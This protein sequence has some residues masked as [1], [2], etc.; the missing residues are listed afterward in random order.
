MHQA[1][2]LGPPENLICFLLADE[3]VLA[4][5]GEVDGIVVE[6][7]YKRQLLLRLFIFK[8]VSMTDKAPVKTG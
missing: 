4:V 5:P 1:V 6:D 8:H 7:V 2:L 3:P